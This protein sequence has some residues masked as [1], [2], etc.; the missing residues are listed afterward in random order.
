MVNSLYKKNADITQCALYINL[1]SED[2]IQILDIFMNLFISVF[3]LRESFVLFS[4]LSLLHFLL[5]P[6]SHLLNDSEAKICYSQ[7]HVYPE[8]PTYNIQTMPVKDKRN[9]SDKGWI[10]SAVSRSELLEPAVSRFV[11][12]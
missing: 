11:I 8:E 10:P 7:V 12:G 4:T 3:F 6:F 9:L 2:T 1:Y 5:Y